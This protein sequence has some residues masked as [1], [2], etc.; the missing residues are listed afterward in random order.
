[1]MFMC[2][3]CFYDDMPDAAEPYNICPCCGTEFGNDDDGRTYAQLRAFWIS[4]GARWFY[5]E[6]PATWNPWIQLASAGVKLPY[7]VNVTVAGPTPSPLYVQRGASP[8]QAPIPSSVYPALA[9]A[10]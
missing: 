4:S 2:P 5:D 1:M 7:L 10:A 3:V 6:R 9:E 8:R